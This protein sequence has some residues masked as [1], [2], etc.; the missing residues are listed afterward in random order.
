MFVPELVRPALLHVAMNH[1]AT[2]CQV[3]LGRTVDLYA[4]LKAANKPVNAQ[5]I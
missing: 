4:V 3:L 5:S 2:Q 1:V